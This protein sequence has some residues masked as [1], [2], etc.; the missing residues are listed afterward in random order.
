MVSS[1]SKIRK[2]LFSNA[3]ITEVVNFLGES[4]EGVNVETV[5]YFGTKGKIVENIK[6]SIGEF[7]FIKFSH[8][9]KTSTVLESEDLILNVFSNDK[10]D[11]FLNKLKKKTKILDEIVDIKAGLKAYEV[12]K[13]NPKQ[14][15]DDVTNRIYDFDFKFDN[16]TFPYLEGKDVQRYVQ[17]KNSSFLKYGDNLAAPR[18]IDIFINPKIIIREITGKHPQSII[19]CYSDET[20]LFNMSN[21]A[22]N[23]KVNSKIELKYILAIINSRLMSYYFQLN[24]AKAVRK[25]FPKIILKDL[26]Q[27]PIKIISQN[28][29]IPFLKLVDKIIETKKQNPSADTTALESQIDQ[30]VYQLYGLTEEEIKIV[31]GV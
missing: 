29:Q 21:I 16:T 20:V 15:R 13:G 23:K 10:T 11:E 17:G 5:S 14:T 19:A 4:F 3:S 22:I 30:L 8:N 25:L 27:F 2:M 1:T 31:E 18:T 24:T 28:E 9:K 6:V 12:G 26:R 7:G